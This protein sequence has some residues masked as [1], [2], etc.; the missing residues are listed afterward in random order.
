MAVEASGISGRDAESGFVPIERYGLIGDSGTAALVTDAGSIDWLCLP[1]F[2]SDP[3]FAALLDPSV[4]GSWVVRPASEVLTSERGYRA[5]T[6]ILSTRYVT[7]S[8][9]A[10]VDD[11]FAAV[12]AVER[13]THL[14][15][16][17]YLVRRIAGESGEV[18]LDVRFEPARPF[19]GTPFRVSSSGLRGSAVAGGHA[20]LL[21]CSEP[22]TTDGNQLLA[23]LHVSTGN[24][25][26]AVLSYAERDLGVLPPVGAFAEDAFQRTAAYWRDWNEAVPDDIPLAGLVARSV[27]VLKLLTFAPSGGVVAAPTT[28]LP[29]AVGAG[30]NW[31]YRYVWVRD[32][33][34]S[35]VALSSNGHADEARSYLGWLLNAASLT[36]PRIR[37]L[38][39][40]F[41]R[42]R[43][44]ER[45]I[46]GLRGYLDSRPVRTGNAAVEQIQL[47]NWGYLLEAVAAFAELAG[48]LDAGTWRA[49]RSYVDFVARAWDRPDHG[50]W[51]VRTEPRQ[52]VHSKVL[53]WV[54]LDRGLN[55]SR[56]LDLP[57][58]RRRWEAERARIRATI[59]ADGYDEG[60]GTFVDVLGG[61][62]VDAALLEIANAGMF[63]PD[64][65]RVA[66]TIDRIRS[67]LGADALVYRH[68]GD[69]GLGGAEG[70]FLPCSFW[71][72][73]ALAKTD[74]RE[75]ALAVLTEAAA[76]A[77]DLGLLPEEVDPVTGRALG[78]FPQGLSHIALV[79]AAT[80]LRGRQPS[81]R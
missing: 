46:A 21:S 33:S 9:S 52:F 59:E 25:A 73:E 1:N 57:G 18:D 81:G 53:S 71:L 8:G 2:D 32:A 26:Y 15:P 44:D 4:G 10:T 76:Y 11:F 34:R 60:A 13:D 61:A 77:N 69:D 48:E 64:D 28:S 17:R 78:N 74:R 41:G 68:R 23:R 3:V 22:I 43:A 35:I 29:E 7:A 45:E 39:D 24:V 16:F 79:N 19:G 63:E 51:E 58:D 66:R 40:I 47:D 6:P 38:Y 12:P 80:V 31:D 65:R 50:I 36:Q 75:E 67:E 70:A 55:L 27:L 49:T 56:D 37:T 30:R 72:A 62:G 5:G 20:L 42:P 14:W 54:A